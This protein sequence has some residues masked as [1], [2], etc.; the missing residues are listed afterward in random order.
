MNNRRIVT[1]RNIHTFKLSENR[2]VPGTKPVLDDEGEIYKIH[3]PGSQFEFH[4]GFKK[5]LLEI[6][7]DDSNTIVQFYAVIDV[8]Y[9]PPSYLVFE[10]DP[11]KLGTVNYSGNL[12]QGGVSDK[13]KW[14]TQMIVSCPFNETNSA[15]LPFNVKKVG[16]G[17]FLTAIIQSLFGTMSGIKLLGLEGYKIPDAEPGTNEIKITQ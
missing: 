4:G 15:G 14:N 12:V 2:Q 8:F 17:A 5:K 13:S 6:Q 3:I 10:K 9:V 16:P 7:A 11:V 1:D